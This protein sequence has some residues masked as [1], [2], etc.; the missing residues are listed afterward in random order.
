MSM[1]LDGFITGL[2]DGLEHPLGLNRFRLHD[3]VSSGGGDP[4]SH[5]PS[6]EVSGKVL[7][8]MMASGAVIAG[9]RT[10]DLVG[11]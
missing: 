1:S 8:E 3:R 9:R 2:S 6:S 5:R 10:F 11:R 4:E 7:D